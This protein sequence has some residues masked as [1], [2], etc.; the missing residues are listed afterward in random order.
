[1]R[2]LG[3][4][5]EQEMAELQL[6]TIDELTLLSNRRFTKKLSILIGLHI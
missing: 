6:A 4:M 3:R 1:M 2:D 5:A